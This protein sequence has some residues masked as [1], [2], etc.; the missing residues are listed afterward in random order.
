MMDGTTNHFKLWT[1]QTK[2]VPVGE[3]RSRRSKENQSLFV[4]RQKMHKKINMAWKY[5]AI[6]VSNNG[7]PRAYLTRKI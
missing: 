6:G 1:D 2:L 3:E 5:K 7:L 4:E